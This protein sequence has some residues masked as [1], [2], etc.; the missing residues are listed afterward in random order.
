MLSY[1]DYLATG[2]LMIILALSSA[3][4]VDSSRRVHVRCRGIECASGNWMEQAQPLRSHALHLTRF[5]PTAE[6]LSRCIPTDRFVDSTWKRIENSS[7]TK[8]DDLHR[9]VS[10][11]IPVGLC[12]Q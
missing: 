12:W 3:L 5:R 8:S 7:A 1:F 6:S 10:N 9:Q 4:T 2:R 11:G